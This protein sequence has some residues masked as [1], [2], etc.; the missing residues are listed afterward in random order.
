MIKNDYRL[1]RFGFLPTAHTEGIW[2]FAT[3]SSVSYDVS[4]ILNEMGDIAGLLPAFSYNGEHTPS[5]TLTSIV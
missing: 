2:R 1:G 4:L 5:S 3:D